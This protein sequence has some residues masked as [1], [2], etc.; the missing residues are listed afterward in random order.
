MC[1]GKGPR[2]EAIFGEI[3]EHDVADIDNPAVSLQFRWC[4]EGNWKLIVPKSGSPLE[5][6]DLS[7]DPHEQRNLAGEQGEVVARLA[8]RLDAWW[9]P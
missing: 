5:L 3:F 2:R 4:I 9:R 7:A 8:Q 1:A 6:Y